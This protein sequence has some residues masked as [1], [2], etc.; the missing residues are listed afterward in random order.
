M[1]EKTAETTRL[2]SA[3]SQ[4][5]AFERARAARQTETAEDYVELIADLIAAQGEARLVDLAKRL[6]VSHPTASKVVERLQREDLV[7]SKPYRSI[8]LT[9]QGEQLARRCKARHQIVTEFL[10]SLGISHGVA[11]IDAEGVEHHVS[12]ETIIAFRRFLVSRGVEVPEL[13]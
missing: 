13:D 11:E 2:P 4:A 7:V 8:F 5:R 6:G 10:R 9:V 3:V 1:D 12:E